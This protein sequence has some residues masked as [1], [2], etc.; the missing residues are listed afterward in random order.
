MANT[1]HLIIGAQDG[2]TT[3]TFERRNPLSGEVA[4]TAI[5]ATVADANA[6]AQAALPGW[7]ALGPTARRALLSKAA[8]TLAAK[9]PR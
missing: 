1:V 5:A 6:A 4:T 2:G 8:D 9:A 7:A 3:A